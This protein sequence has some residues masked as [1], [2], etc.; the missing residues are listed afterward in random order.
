MTN[1]EILCLYTD[2]GPDHWATFLSVQM[3][4]T[5]LFLRHDK[6]ILIAVRTP[7]CN[8]GKNP[9]ERIM[10]ILNQELQCIGLVRQKCLDEIEEKLTPSSTMKDVCNLADK[11]PEIITQ[12]LTSIAPVKEFL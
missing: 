9:P 12:V 5:C 11:D 7:P 3:A 8:S 1:R 10:S 6:D 2:G 4:L